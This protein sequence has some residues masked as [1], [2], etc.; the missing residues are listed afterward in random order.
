M[1]LQNKTLS[2]EGDREQMK[3]MDGVKDSILTQEGLI[4]IPNKLG[5][6][7]KDLKVQAWI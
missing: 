4:D 7:S 3:Q 6:L 2:T 5:N 1:S